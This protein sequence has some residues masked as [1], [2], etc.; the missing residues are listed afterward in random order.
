M[1]LKGT[2]VNKLFGHSRD[3][4]SDAAYNSSMDRAVVVSEIVQSPNCGI[5]KTSLPRFQ[6][7][8]K[9]ELFQ[10]SRLRV[11]FYHNHGSTSYLYASKLTTDACEDTCTKE[12]A[13]EVLLPS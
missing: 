7:I 10:R 5:A 4:T 11:F 6:S 2:A 3:I 9:I 1:A 13:S 8:H 12:N